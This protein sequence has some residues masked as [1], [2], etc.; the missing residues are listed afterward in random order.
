MGAPTETT[1]A[2]FDELIQFFY[3]ARNV[4]VRKKPA[5]A[6]LIGW[7][8]LLELDGYFTELDPD[9]RKSMQEYNLSFLVKTREDLEAV[10]KLL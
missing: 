5:T 2:A 10:R 9:K 7:L 6:E 8:Q 4:S 1:K 3:N